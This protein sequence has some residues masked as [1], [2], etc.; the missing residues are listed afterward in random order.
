VVVLVTGVAKAYALHMAVEEGINH[1]WTVSMIQTHPRAVVICD[2]DSTAELKVR[3][4][5]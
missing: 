3:N 5:D 1:M 4:I 2:E